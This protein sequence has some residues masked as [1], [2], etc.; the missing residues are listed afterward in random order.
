[1]PR[2]IEIKA[3][4]AS[5]EALAPLAAAIAD[6]GPFEIVQDDTFFVCQAGKLKL[7][8][9]SHDQGELIFYRR[10]NQQ[11]PKESFYLRSPTPEPDT[12]RESLSL[13]YG[14]AGRVQKH[15][16]L[17]LV[18]RTRIH[19]DEV[20]ALGHFLELEVVLADDEPSEVGVHE[21]HE[22]MARLGVGPAQLI[23]EAYVDLLANSASNSSSERTAT[24]GL[25]PL[26]SAATSVVMSRKYARLEIERR[27]LVSEDVRSSTSSAPYSDIEDRYVTGTRLRLR[28]VTSCDGA[29][30]WKFCKKYPRA[31][32]DTYESITNLYLS[33]AEVEV[34]SAL[35][36]SIVRKRRYRLAVGSLDVY[37]HPRALNVFEVE[38]ET[39]VEAQGFVPPPFAGREIT[40][41]ESLSGAALAGAST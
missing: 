29:T 25:R 19:L 21:A 7:R 28:R 30:Q 31:G 12:L 18:G 40:G 15:R 26:A 6:Q 34:L 8:A 33:K 4:I 3:R 9:F 37:T 36:C 17:F 14:Q 20:A 22:L 35:P 23:K 13:A 1:M 2:N 16:T 39:E 32:G 11:G 27:W 24:S 10:A 41:E 38:F 5:V